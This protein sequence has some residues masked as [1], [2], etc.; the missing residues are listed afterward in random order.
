MPGLIDPENRPLRPPLRSPVQGVTKGVGSGNAVSGSG[1][2]GMPP[3]A[4]AGTRLA[5]SPHWKPRSARKAPVYTHRKHPKEKAPPAKLPSEAFTAAK[6]KALRAARGIRRKFGQGLTR[7][8][9][10]RLANVFRSAV[11]PR[12]KPGRPPKP[13]IT[14]AYLD[15]K[16]GMRGAEL[17]R[18]HIPGWEGHNRYHRKGEQKELMDAIRSRRRRE[19]APQS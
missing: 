9:C 5:D 14:A 15:W 8:D 4:T 10:I 1:E 17:Y 16:A 19:R 7:E 12:Q 2:A 13:E 11:V 3:E 18:S 6:E